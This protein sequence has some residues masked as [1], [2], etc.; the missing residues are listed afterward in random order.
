MSADPLWPFFVDALQYS[1]VLPYVPEYSNWWGDIVANS[2]E[3]V[4]AG[5]VSP[6]DMV[7]DAQEQIDASF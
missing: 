7:K 1:K 6:E 2:L 4:W 5:F 3:D